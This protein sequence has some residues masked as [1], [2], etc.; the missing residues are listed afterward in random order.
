[1]PINFWRPRKHT[2]AFAALS[3]S[4]GIRKSLPPI[5]EPGGIQALAAAYPAMSLLSELLG[6]KLMSFGSWEVLQFRS[7]TESTDRIKRRK[8]KTTLF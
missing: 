6:V 7:W 4:T 2:V 8:K 1:M 5:G 3:I